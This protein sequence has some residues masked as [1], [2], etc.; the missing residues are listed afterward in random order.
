MPEIQIKATHS[1]LYRVFSR[2][3]TGDKRKG[4]KKGIDF[5]PIPK[6]LGKTISFS[7][8]SSH[9]DNPVYHTKCIKRVGGFPNKVM[10][11]VA[12]PGI[13]VALT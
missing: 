10:A 12:T 11:L 1:S 2:G 7:S 9:C 13:D 6:K 8:L 4:V 3:G 5:Q